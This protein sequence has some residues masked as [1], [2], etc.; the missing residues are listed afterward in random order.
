M[1][2][3][4]PSKWKCAQIIFSYLELALRPL[5]FRLKRGL[6]I[7]PSKYRFLKIFSSKFIYILEGL[8]S[9]E[10]LI[11]MAF[12]V[13]YWIIFIQS[14]TRIESRINLFMLLL[15]IFNFWEIQNPFSLKCFFRSWISK[16]VIPSFQPK[17]FVPSSIEK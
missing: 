11:F 15:P 10:S 7:A 5:S 12:E 13:A 3:L 9:Y 16:C 2:E 8:L 4:L 1:T 17:T 14:E 6:K